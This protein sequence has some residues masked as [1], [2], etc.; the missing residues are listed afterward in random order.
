MPFPPGNLLPIYH[1]LKIVSVVHPNSNFMRSIKVSL[2]TGFLIILLTFTNLSIAQRAIW[3]EDS[4]ML[5]GPGYGLDRYH[6]VLRFHDPSMYLVFPIVHP[7]TERSVPLQDG[8]GKNGYWLEGHLGHRFTVYKGKYYSAPFFQ[9]MRWTLDVSLLSM[10]TRDESSP[11]LPFNNKIGP[12]LD[13]LLSS[14]SGLKAQKGGMA[15]ATFQLHH[16]SNGQADSFFLETPEKRNNYKSGNF[17][18]NYFRGLMNFA[19]NK[20]NLL[21]TTLGYHKE[22]DVGGALGR[23]TELK[24]YYGD[25]RILFQLNWI[26]KPWIRTRTYVDRSRPGAVNVEADKRR[27]LGIRTEFEYIMGDLSAFPGSNK[28]RL[29]W[30]NYITYL[31]SVTNEVGFMVHTYLGRHYLNIRFDDIVFA[32]G[33]GFTVKFN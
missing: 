12:G 10:L 2:A 19:V 25:E 6:E 9:R 7:T 3:S 27:Q 23:S 16:Y 17:S 1:G 22:V 13:F 30:H 26:K 33:L 28:Q 32:A 21:I 8:E 18:T 31:P 24:N 4:L 15:W 20:K 14:L 5:T 29:G 11:I